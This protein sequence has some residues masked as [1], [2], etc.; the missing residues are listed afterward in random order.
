MSCEKDRVF[1]RE[2]LILKSVSWIMR[3][4]WGDVVT[5]VDK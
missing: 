4:R 5:A 2:F 3:C 1:E